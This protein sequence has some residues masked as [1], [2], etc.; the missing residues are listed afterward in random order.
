MDDDLLEPVEDLIFNIDSF[1][2]NSDL[3][4]II[5]PTTRVLMIADNDGKLK[6]HCRTIPSYNSSFS[7]NT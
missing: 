3:F 4:S 5:D 2:E 1:S 6:I 7:Y